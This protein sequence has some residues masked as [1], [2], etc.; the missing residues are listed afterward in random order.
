MKPYLLFMLAFGGG[1][2]IGSA[3]VSSMGLSAPEA[4]R[5]NRPD[6]SGQSL[7]QESGES[8]S[9][10]T[11][12]VPEQSEVAPPQGAAPG[13]EFGPAASPE[14][15]EASAPHE[16]GRY[17]QTHPHNPVSSFSPVWG[18]LKRSELVAGSAEHWLRHKFEFSTVGSSGRLD[19]SENPIDQVRFEQRHADRLESLRSHLARTVHRTPPPWRASQFQIVG[20]LD[21][22]FPVVI[23]GRDFLI[24]SSP[25]QALSWIEAHRELKASDADRERALHILE[26]WQSERRVHT[27]KI[28]NRLIE[29]M[30]EGTPETLNPPL[31]AYVIVGRKLRVFRQ[32]EIPEL[33]ATLE[34]GSELMNQAVAE[35][36]DVINREE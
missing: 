34:L 1:W 27:A 36:K 12:R 23:T 5:Q 7:S 3:W 9:G 21:P 13:Q 6:E 16:E 19:K 29:S 32:G 24:P 10:R 28:W 30:I 31:S 25:E 15:G 22:R 14:P 18:N 35:A 4:S 33:D 17:R 11:V 2:G 8:P 26:V 20:S